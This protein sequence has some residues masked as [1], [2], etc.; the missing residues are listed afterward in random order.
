MGKRILLDLII[1]RKCESFPNAN[2]A[3]GSSWSCGFA[4]LKAAHRSVWTSYVTL[5]HKTSLK[6]LG[7]ICSNSQQYI[8]WVKILDFTF[9]PKIIRTLIKDHVP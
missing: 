9:M 7:H 1:L 4:T 2:F 6:S 8:V 3:L 5:E